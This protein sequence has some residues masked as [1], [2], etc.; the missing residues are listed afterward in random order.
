MGVFFVAQLGH[1]GRQGGKALNLQLVS[2]SEVE[3]VKEW[4]RMSLRN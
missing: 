2:A 1:L 4:R 3:L